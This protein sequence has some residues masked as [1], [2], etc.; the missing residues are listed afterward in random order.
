MLKDVFSGFADFFQHV[1]NV[2]EKR[3][4]FN[5]EVSFADTAGG[6]AR[7]RTVIIVFQQN[8]V[9]NIP[10][11][12]LLGPVVLFASQFLT[13]FV[14]LQCGVSFFVNWF[15]FNLPDNIIIFDIRI[16]N[17]SSSSPSQDKLRHFVKNN[18]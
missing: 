5:G 16:A 13:P 6:N 11:I 1:K 10:Q 14:I 8:I 7:N 2:T 17:F 3:I 4:I 15:C 9:V 18:F 12:G